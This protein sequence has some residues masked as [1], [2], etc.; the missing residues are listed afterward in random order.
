M[1][2]FYRTDVLWTETPFSLTMDLGTLAGLFNASEATVSEGTEYYH[3]TWFS[4]QSGGRGLLLYPKDTVFLRSRNDQG[5]VTIWPASVALADD[6]NF[7]AE[8]V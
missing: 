7:V 8:S 5:S 1:T 3:L 2:A 4:N 6:P